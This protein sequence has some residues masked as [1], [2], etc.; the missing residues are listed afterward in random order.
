MEL[1]MVVVVVELGKVK[2]VKKLMKTGGKQKKGKHLCKIIVGASSIA[3]WS[4]RVS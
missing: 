1:M 3:T 2:I 4:H